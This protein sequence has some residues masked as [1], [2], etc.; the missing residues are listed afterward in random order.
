MYSHAVVGYV[1]NCV[2]QRMSDSYWLD[3]L[4]IVV[5]SVEEPLRHNVARWWMVKMVRDQVPLGN[6]P[7]TVGFLDTLR[8]SLGV[9]EGGEER[10]KEFPAG[11]TQTTSKQN[12]MTSRW[13]RGTKQAG[14]AQRPGYSQ[15]PEAMEDSG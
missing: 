7:V 14:H 8:G 11:Y 5:S 2:T 12:T 15:I 3:E 10:T 13:Y 4:V 1:T 6:D 9:Q